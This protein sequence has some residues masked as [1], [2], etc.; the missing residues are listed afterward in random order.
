MFGTGLLVFL[1]SSDYSG[2]V[3][4]GEESCLV[5]EIVDHPVRDN[6]DDYGDQ[7]FENE[8]PSLG[9]EDVS[10]RLQV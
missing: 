7:A 5:G 8:N 4:D 10:F 9:S 2:A 6:A 3:V 1:E